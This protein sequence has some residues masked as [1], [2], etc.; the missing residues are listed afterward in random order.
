MMIFAKPSLLG[1]GL[2]VIGCS[3]LSLQSGETV[4]TEN[5]STIAVQSEEVAKATN[6][7]ERLAA[8]WQERQKDINGNDYPIGPGDVLEI[9]TEDLSE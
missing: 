7:L 8:L 1:L 6:D 4:G 9:N 5:V 2:F 3:Q